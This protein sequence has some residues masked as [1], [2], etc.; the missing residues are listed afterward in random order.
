MAFKQYGHIKNDVYSFYIKPFIIGPYVYAKSKIGVCLF[1][2]L[3]IW[4]KGFTCNLIMFILERCEIN[5][6]P[7][8]FLI[9]FL[10]TYIQKKYTKFLL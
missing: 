1:D 6:F 3:S 9:I 7:V 8:T 4:T 10:V 5:V 2:K